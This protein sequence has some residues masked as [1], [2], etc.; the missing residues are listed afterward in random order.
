MVSRGLIVV[1]A[2]A[3]A[4]SIQESH[5]QSISPHIAL[6]TAT[7]NI[8]A[9]TVHRIPDGGSWLQ[10]TEDGMALTEGDRIIAWPKATAIITFLDGSTV[11][12]E[13]N[14]EVAVKTMAIHGSIRS[15]ITI[16][17]I[18]G[19]VWARVAPMRDPKAS[20][21][22]ESST[23]TA[24]VH[25][26]LIGG[27]QAAD[28]SFACWTRAGTLTVK[29]PQGHALLTLQPNEHTTVQAG[30]KPLSQ[31]FVMN[32][33]MLLVTASSNVLPL[34]EMPDKLRVAGFVAPVWEVNQVFG[35]ITGRTAN[36]AYFVEVPAGVPGPFLLVVHGL[37]DG[38]F[39]VTLVGTFKGAPIYQQELSGTI[40][41]GERLRT[42][43]TQQMDPATKQEPLTAKV[44][45]GSAVPLS[46][47]HGPLPGII[48]LSPLEL[49][50][51][52]GR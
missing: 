51:N 5:A 16:R 11:T 10:A 29:D 18:F 21:S 6:P 17:I 46:L 4:L 42:E 36:K 23:A 41:K 1:L 8:L 49:K 26:G 12:V 32:H 19:A 38:P 25:N 37:H 50:A 3:V 44:T 31:P 52:G 27:R 33:T 24:T 14:S 2:L 48:V 40:K 34:I 13:P 28:G 15:A 47:W 9:G 39:K 22:L 35:A 7:L 30:K 43:I 45:S 20:F